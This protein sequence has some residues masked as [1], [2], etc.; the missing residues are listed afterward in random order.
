MCTVQHIA[1]PN[2]QTSTGISLSFSDVESQAAALWFP[3][4]D[5]PKSNCCPT[6]IIENVD[7]I[8]EIIEVDRHVSSRSI[9]QELKIDHKTVLSHLSKIGF[10]KKI[11]GQTLNSDIYCPQL[12]RFNL[13]TDLK[14]TEL[15]NMRGVVF[16]QG[17]ARPHTS[18]VTRQKLWELD[19]K[20]LMHPPHSPDLAPNDYHLFLVLQDFQ[21]D[22]KL[23]SKY[24]EN[25]LLEFFSNKGQDF[26]ERGNMKLHLKWQQIIQQNGTYLTQ[27]GQ[28]EAC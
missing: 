5:M 2:N 23:G 17:N 9:A 12:D 7:K 15:A 13:A 25:R 19:W 11:D 20:V 28:S 14:R 1:C 18:A 8:T 6:P 27:I 10:K 26:Y 16:H 21:S 22:K 4:D 24:C 3:P